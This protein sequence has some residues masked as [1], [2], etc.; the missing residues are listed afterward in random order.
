[1]MKPGRLRVFKSCKGVRDELGSYRRKLDAAGDP[2]EVIVDKRTYHRADS[3][4]Y[5]C[6]RITDGPKTVRGGFDF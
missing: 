6:I 3:L 5:A 2:T 4:R 1:M